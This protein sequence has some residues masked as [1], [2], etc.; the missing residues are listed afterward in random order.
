M[1]TAQKTSQQAYSQTW[2][3]LVVYKQASVNR[4]NVQSHN[5]RER[6]IRSQLEDT[7]T[8]MSYISLQP[9]P[10]ARRFRDRLIMAAIDMIIVCD[11]SRS[12][13]G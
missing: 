4:I 6:R 11:I 8:D 9:S 13:L 12:A 3:D 5:E 2:T 10:H 1:S 7:L